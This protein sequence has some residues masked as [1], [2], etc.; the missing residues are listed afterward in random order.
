MGEKEAE[1][2]APRGV[3]CYLLVLHGDGEPHG[4]AMVGRAKKDLLVP[5]VREKIKLSASILV[6]IYFHQP[7][8]YFL[9]SF[10]SYWAPFLSD[11]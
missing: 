3:G 10:M 9:P 5:R 8:R 4:I 2:R 1:K 11:L 6:N 7:G